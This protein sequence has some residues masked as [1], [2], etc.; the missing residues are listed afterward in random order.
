[1][2]SSTVV[3]IVCVILIL[4]LLLM[5]TSFLIVTLRKRSKMQ[6]SCKGQPLQDFSHNHRVPLAVFDYEEIK[7][8]RHNGAPTV[9]STVCLPT[10]PSD[11][12]KT[13]YA[14]AQPPS[15]SHDMDIYSTAQLSTTP[16]DSSV[17]HGLQLAST[18]AEG[19]T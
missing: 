13:V 7:D 8:T 1:F 19:L 11:P 14:L 12:S 4:V 9:Y 10:N 6:A 3:S 18:S 16:S 5:G 17:G 15:C 2:P